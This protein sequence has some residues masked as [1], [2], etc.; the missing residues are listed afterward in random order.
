M[1]NSR[2]PGLLGYL[3]VGVIV[4]MTAANSYAASNIYDFTLPL[5]NGKDAP[6][7]NY[8]GKVVLVVN[9]ASRCG[10]TPQYT[11]LEVHLRKVQ[12]PGLRDCRLPGE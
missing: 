9:V 5:L 1:T 3:L 4:L 7:A 2:R 6:L 11:A 12:G 8:K 10:F